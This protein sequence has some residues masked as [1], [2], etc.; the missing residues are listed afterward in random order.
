MGRSCY[1]KSL[2]DC[3]GKLT[4]EH[5]VS[6]SL[7]DLG[8]DDTNGIL[9]GGALDIGVPTS[10]ANLANA[11]VLCRRHN[12]MLSPL[13]S[14]FTRLAERI[15]IFNRDG[16]HA[17]DSFDG[18]KITR[19][20]IKCLFGSL[21]AGRSRLGL[22]SLRPGALEDFLPLL[23]G[24]DVIPS[25]LGFSVPHEPRLAPFPAEI[26]VNGGFPPWAMAPREILT[27]RGI[28]VGLLESFLYPLRLRVALSGPEQ[29][30]QVE[31]YRPASVTMNS[32]ERKTSLRLE[33]TWP[34]DWRGGDVV[35]ELG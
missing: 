27:S 33:F 5:Y 10:S 23:F 12:Q 11:K 17:E 31:R 16:G 3:E 4:R 20:H 14:E 25:W 2:G 30:S 7:L 22:G 24:V 8:Q 6:R 35:H 13:D 21:A 29:F 15:M 26:M 19:W 1:A 34:N 32:Q 18:D 28:K 9:L